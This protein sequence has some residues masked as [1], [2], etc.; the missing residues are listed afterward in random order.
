M[1][2]VPVS[3][4]RSTGGYEIRLQG[5]LQ[6]RWAAWFEGLRITNEGDGTTLIRGPVADQAALQGLLRK[7]GDLGLTLVSVTQVG[8]DQ[9][10]APPPDNPSLTSHQGEPS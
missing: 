2:E 4:R 1:S 9:S 10:D 7:L 6:P 8:P 5:H 3:H